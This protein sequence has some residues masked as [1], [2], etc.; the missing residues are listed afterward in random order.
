M[1]CLASLF[2]TFSQ[3]VGQASKSSAGQAT[4]LVFV[5]VVVAF[6]VAVILRRRL[7]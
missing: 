1:L 6:Y 2:D 4:A 7:K 3:Q 5:T